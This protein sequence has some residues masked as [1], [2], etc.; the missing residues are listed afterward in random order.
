MKKLLYL[1]FFI[2]FLTD[3]LVAN[4]R[5][6]ELNILFN[7][8]QDTNSKFTSEIEQKIWKIWST[9]PKNNELTLMLL[10]GSK[11]ADNQKLNEAVKL[12]SEVIEIDP[13]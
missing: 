12:F 6:K 11:L 7:K 3:Q 13:Y 1:F 5:E 8:L 10:K 2:F 9:H 4:E